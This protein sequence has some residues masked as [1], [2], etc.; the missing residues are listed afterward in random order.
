MFIFTLNYMSKR[1]LC[2]R[3]CVQGCM[4]LL[5]VLYN[6]IIYCKWSVRV[7]YEQKILMYSL[8]DWPL[9]IFFSCK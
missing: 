2:A 7:K 3:L 5:S 1:D 8:Q 6:T 9:F 4:F